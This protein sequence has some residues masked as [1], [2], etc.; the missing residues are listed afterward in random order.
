MAQDQLDLFEQWLPV[1]GYE[2]RYEVSN[3]GGVRSLLWPRPR[4]LKRIAR[5]DCYWGVTLY[6]GTQR[7]FY[8]HRL[9]AAAFVPNPSD[10]IEVMH[11]DSDPNNCAAVNL[12]WGSRQMNVD[13]S[14]GAFD[15]LPWALKS[16]DDDCPF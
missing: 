10:H 5:G 14:N 1:A 11:L 12:M 16:V 8:V 15:P 9:V 3:Q 13:H 2:G 6:N 4:A 7:N